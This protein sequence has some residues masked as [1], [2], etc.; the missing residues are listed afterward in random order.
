GC[1]VDDEAFCARAAEAAR[2]LVA[3]DAA[4]LLEL[5][6]PERFECTDVDVEF[7]PA[8]ETSSVLEGYPLTDARFAIEVL[9]R[10]AYRRQ[11]DAILSSIEASY[12]DE[13]GD[14]SPTIL[15]VGTC[16]PPDPE[17]RSYHLV[18]TAAASEGG[19]E[20]ERLL[21]SFEFTYDHDWAIALWFLDTV[22]G[23]GQVYT[24]P[25]AEI[26]CAGAADPWLR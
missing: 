23:W 19:S 9:D 15:G 25:F 26:G 18:W 13:Q 6:R 1:P 10:S 16:G 24:D 3:G 4:A 21:G 22:D 8:C 2:A 20:P 12:S 17:R 11:L 7:F 14:G 5:S